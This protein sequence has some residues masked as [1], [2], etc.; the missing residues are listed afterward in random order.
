MKRRRN[1]PRNPFEA[2]SLKHT[3][4]IAGICVHDDRELCAKCQITRA[5][6]AQ[7]DKGLPVEDLF[8]I[9][10]RL[11]AELIAGDAGG[12]IKHRLLEKTFVSWLGPTVKLVEVG[13]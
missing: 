3:Q 11:A 5:V 13:Q 9:Y 6:Q 2:L 10:V 12:E 7:V 1:H 8:Y 4:I